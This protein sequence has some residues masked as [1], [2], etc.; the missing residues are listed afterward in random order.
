MAMQSGAH[1]SCAESVRSGL[2]T[3]GAALALDCLNRACAESGP[4]RKSNIG[5]IETTGL[6]HAE[7]IDLMVNRY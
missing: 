6:I 7:R 4:A 2:P 5:K 1:A 3:S